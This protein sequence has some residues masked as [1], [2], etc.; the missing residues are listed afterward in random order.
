[1]PAVLTKLVVW[2]ANYNLNGCVRYVGSACIMMFWMNECYVRWFVY[3]MVINSFITFGALYW[4]IRQS[5][6][7]RITLI[8]HNM[9]NSHVLLFTLYCIHT[10]LKFNST[11]SFIS[12]CVTRT[13][14]TEISSFLIWLILK[15]IMYNI[16]TCVFMFLK[17]FIVINDTASYKRKVY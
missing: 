10:Q 7:M 14:T 9:Q 3:Y 11:V 5:G 16:S 15:W 2:F 1:M 8:A 13:F 6:R 12:T 4:W 17:V